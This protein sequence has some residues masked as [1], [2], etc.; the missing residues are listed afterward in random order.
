MRH[1]DAIIIGS[2]QGG[3]PLA[4]KLAYQ[5]RSVALFERKAL[6]GTCLNVGCY[7]SKAFLGAAHTGGDTARSR[8]WGIEMKRQI[9]FA[10]LMSRVRSKRDSGYIKAALDQ[11]GVTTIMAEASFEGERTIATE[12]G[13]FSAELI[14]VN[15]GNIPFV[16]PIPGLA[17]TPFM[18]YQDFWELNDLP[19]RLIVVGGGYIG[20][21]LGQGMARLGS[22]VHLVEP[23]ER[24]LSREEPDLSAALQAALERDGIRFHLGR[25]IQEVSHESSVFRARLDGGRWLEGD[26]MLVVAGQQ[27]NTGALNLEATGVITD[28]RGFIKVDDRLETTC[29]GIYAIG[30]VTGQPAFTHVS[31]EDHRR[32]LSVLEG[33]DRRQGDRVLGYAVFTDPEAGRCGLTLEDALDRGLD[34]RVA[35]LA[36]EHVARAWLID[37]DQGFYRIVVE[38]G[39]DR[40]LG[41]TLVG[42]RAGELVHVFIDLMETGATWRQL[43]AAVHIHPTYAEGLPTVARQLLKK[44]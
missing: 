30:D 19:R 38:N 26:A 41:A 8:A 42:P 44:P 7:P 27:P 12:A 31:W 20:V 24:I 18:T 40:I 36:L 21:E 6:G 13:P 3:V 4:V 10:R 35:N 14:V 34:A 43:E 23:L 33:G 39:T 2:G 28:S 17:G 29:S 16:P 9:D 25:P 37:R 1:F 11:A 32:V 15:T 22:E 5:G